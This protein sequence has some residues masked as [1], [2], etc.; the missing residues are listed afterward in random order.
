MSEL[1][2]VAWLCIADDGENVDAVCS[3]FRR[4][5]YERFGRKIVP[6]YAIPAGYALVPVEPTDAMLDE[7]KTDDRYTNRAMRV[8]YLAM[9]N[10]AGAYDIADAQF[11]KGSVV[12]DR[13]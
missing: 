3:E 13:A 4:S 9:L 1:K 10:S 5:E 12:D 7:I 2:P 6:L 8:R 11:Q